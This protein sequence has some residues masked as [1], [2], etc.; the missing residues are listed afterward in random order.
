MY[1]LAERRSSDLSEVMLSEFRGIAF[2]ETPTRFLN[3]TR[4][5]RLSYQLGFRHLSS[6]DWAPSLRACMLGVTTTLSKFRFSF[7]FAGCAGMELLLAVGSQRGLVD[8]CVY[9]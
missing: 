5:N 2:R 6:M 7:W 8:I 4:G 1:P 3:Y 9:V